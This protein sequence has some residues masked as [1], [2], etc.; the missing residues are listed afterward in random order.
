MSRPLITLTTDFGVSSPYV[1]QMKGA[2]WQRCP[3]ANVVDLTHAIPPQ[4]I[5]AG[6]IALRDTVPHFP[7]GTIHIA[8]VDPGVG[9]GRRI[10]CVETSDHFLI[11]PDNGLLS[12]VVATTPARR[13]VAIDYQRVNAGEVSATFHGRDVMAPAA[14]RLA[15]G[16]DLQSLGE[17]VDTLEPLLYPVVALHDG[18]L[19][20]C[21]THFDSFG[22]AISNITR[23]DIAA[24]GFH[25][26]DACVQV[27]DQ[28]LHGLVQHYAQRPPGECV[29]LLGSSGY[30]E[31]A[32]VNGS[33]KAGLNLSVGQEIVLQPATRK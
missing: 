15:L 33:A 7:R 8:V 12:L 16:E 24:A 14:A 1:A 22:N 27:G 32:S 25:A 19:R 5:Q 29:A 11:G 30:L 17:L 2:I 3:D 21:V 13:I 4:D 6:A 23:S 28:V 18:C 31:I 10:V 20:G 9:S 26:S